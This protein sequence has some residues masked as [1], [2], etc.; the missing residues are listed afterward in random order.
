MGFAC[1]TLGLTYL[2]ND[3]ACRYIQLV[4]PRVVATAVST[5]RA[6]WMMSFQMFLFSIVVD[7]LYLI[8]G[9]GY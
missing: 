2:I 4:T 8:G 6:S 1:F 3:V 5:E 7:F 9:M